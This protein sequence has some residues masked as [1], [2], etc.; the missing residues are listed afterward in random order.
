MEETIV[1]KLRTLATE[2][3]GT[4]QIGY[5]TYV[6]SVTFPDALD[7]GVIRTAHRIANG[8]TVTT[9]E[10]GDLLYYIADLME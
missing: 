3:Q 7:V 5:S 6:D 2:I 1:Q 10:L 4:H 9:D 8:G